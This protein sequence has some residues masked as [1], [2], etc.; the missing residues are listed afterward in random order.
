MKTLV[1]D[2]LDIADHFLSTLSEKEKETKYFLSENLGFSV[3]GG[4]AVIDKKYINWHRNSEN[5]LR[6]DSEYRVKFTFA[7]LG[8]HAE[9][10]DN[11]MLHV[12]YQIPR[13]LSSV[14]DRS[15]SRCLSGGSRIA[16]LDDR[17]KHEADIMAW[18]SAVAVIQRIVSNARGNDD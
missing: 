6:A 14:V 11:G 2:L 16:M 8:G 9:L 1:E 17:P 10:D 5:N 12:R 13:L 18:D 4:Y 7:V 3:P 15:G